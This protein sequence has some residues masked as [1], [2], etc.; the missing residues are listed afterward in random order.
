MPT[1]LFIHP[2]TEETKEVFQKI[3]EPHFYV[4]EKG[5]EWRR[6]FTSPNVAANTNVDPFSAESFRDKTG[7]GGNLGDLYDRAR[8]AHEKRKDKLGHDPVQEKW[9]KSYSK[10]RKGKKHPNDPSK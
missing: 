8:D 6:V 5:V 9:F 7:K 4:D 3:K 10:K 1:Y 2:G